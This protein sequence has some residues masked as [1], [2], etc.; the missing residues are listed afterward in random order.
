MTHR[1]YLHTQA[2]DP[3]PA[4]VEAMLGDLGTTGHI[5]AYYA[6]FERGILQGLAEALPDYHEQLLALAD[7][8]WDQLDVF[9]RFY[10]HYGFGKSNSL[11]SVLPV[12]VPELRYDA[13][14][15]QD[16]GQAQVVWEQ[17]VVTETATEKERLAEQLR[18]YCQMDTWGMVKMHQALAEF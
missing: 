8:L 2:D 11:K 14:D 15:I 17:M 6:P 5:I 10:R 13:L 1:E 3:R 18:A 12:I 16:G 9:K 7:R 4:L